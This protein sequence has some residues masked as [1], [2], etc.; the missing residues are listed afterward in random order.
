MLQHIL[1]IR[2]SGVYETELWKTWIIKQIY[3]KLSFKA[4]YGES[5]MN[6]IWDSV[7]ELRTCICYSKFPEVC[8]SM[9]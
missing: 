4:I 5:V 1:M 2:D 6:V 9:L 7:S 8:V 3:F